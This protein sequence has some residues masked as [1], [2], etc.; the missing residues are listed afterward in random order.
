[1]P[2]DYEKKQKAESGKRKL[3]PQKITKSVKK[4]SSELGC[5]FCDY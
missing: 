1:M 4:L 3:Q 2:E 5:E